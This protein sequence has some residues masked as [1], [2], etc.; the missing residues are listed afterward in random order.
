MGIHEANYLVAQTVC[1]SCI[2]DPVKRIRRANLVVLGAKNAPR[3]LESIAIILVRV[4]Q[5]EKSFSEIQ[6]C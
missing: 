1:S 6:K 5:K 4:A 3:N 2:Q